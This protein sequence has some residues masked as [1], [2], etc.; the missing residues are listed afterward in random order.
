MNRIKEFRELHKIT[1]T[2][3]AKTLETN[4]K[5]ISLYETGKR[6]LNEDQ[7]A[8]ICKY[9]HVTSDWLLGLDED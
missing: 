3:L 7:I 8:R 9:Y 1:Q 5:Q 6:K 2:E 4:Q